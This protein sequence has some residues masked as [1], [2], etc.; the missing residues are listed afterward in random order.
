MLNFIQKYFESSLIA[1]SLKNIAL[2]PKELCPL[3]QECIKTKE[4]VPLFQPLSKVAIK[5][6]REF[7]T[8]ESVNKVNKH[9]RL[10]WKWEVFYWI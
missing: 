2:N 5:E 9:V 4:V 3:Y 8:P 6:S 7:D 1:C 10:S